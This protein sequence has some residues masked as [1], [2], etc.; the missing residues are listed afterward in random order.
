MMPASATSGELQQLN[1]L[2]RGEPEFLRAWI[3]SRGTGRLMLCFGVILA[4]T[5]LYGAAMG[6]WRDANQA[7]F[8]AIKFPLIILLTTVGNAFLN[9]MLAPLLGVDI[10]LRQSF[11]AILTSFA[12]AAAILGSFSPLAAFLVW[13]SPP[14]SSQVRL[15]GAPYDFILL[16]HVGVIAF[17]GMAANL[18]LGR[19]LRQLGG[20]SAGARRVL[21]AWLAGNM[22][23]GSQ[24]SWIFR[25]FIGSPTLPVEFMRANVFQ[26]NFYE[27]VF[28]SLRNLLN[29]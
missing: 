18:R 26:G 10:N 20:S 19:L 6:C 23:L 12:I 29:Q 17:A 8:V 5:G 9:A 14:M 21:F 16:T 25:P 1:L 7:L 28:K 15:S 3:E 4:G 24:L 13:N 11:L 22:F 2:L 27:A